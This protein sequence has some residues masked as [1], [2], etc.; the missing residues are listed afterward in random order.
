MLDIGYTSDESLFT[1]VQLRPASD[2]IP[3]LRLRCLIWY[4]QRR[5]IAV[6]VQLKVDHH[7]VWHLEIAD[8]IGRRRP[9]CAS[10]DMQPLSMDRERG[11]YTPHRIVHE[12]PSHTAAMTE[13]SAM[14]E[15]RR[16]N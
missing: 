7:L 16:T 8:G 9:N 2:T 5:P 10:L 3:E 15:A 12:M 6:S 14:I 4:T 13:A 1:P 11:Y